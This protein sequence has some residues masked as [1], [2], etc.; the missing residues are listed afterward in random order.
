MYVYEIIVY[1]HFMG[2]EGACLTRG[3]Y[4]ADTK[5]EMKKS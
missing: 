3:M 2:I 1:S 4:N 5:T